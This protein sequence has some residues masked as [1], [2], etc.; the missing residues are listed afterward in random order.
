M[1]YIEQTWNRLSL[2]L[3]ATSTQ[4]Y[5]QKKYT[6]SGFANS[7]ALSYQN[8]QPFMYYLE[9][10]KVYY[11]Q[12]QTANLAIR[13]ILQFYGFIQL[14]KACLLTVDAS[15]P[16]S[17]AALAHG[18]S[19]RKRKKQ[20]YSFLLDEVKIQKNGLFTQVGEKMFQ[21]KQ[22]EGNKIKMIDLLSQISELSD[23]LGYFQLPK[24]T[25]LYQV[26]KHEFTV[27]SFILDT[28]HMTTNRFENFMQS[29]FSLPIGVSEK[30][31]IVSLKFESNLMNY[32]LVP[33]RFNLFNQ[34]Y[35]IIPLKDH[36]NVYFSE[37]MVHYLLL[38]NLSMIAR[39]ETEWWIDLTK[40]TPNEDFPL[41][42]KFLDIS[43]QKTPFLI[44]NWLFLS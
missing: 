24:S 39:Y 27:D 42:H 23:E 43:Q 4:K 37:L 18:V 40:T 35:Y 17:S 1:D 21:I 14:L 10:A 20:H 6:Q 26:N 5:L 9:Y 29:T 38:Y 34:H 13:P 11:S 33:I 28:L 19:T 15:Y 25:R 2:L 30:N 12:A 36:K 44:A 16:D 7:D 3:S 8:C 31:K 22:L 41:I 32:N